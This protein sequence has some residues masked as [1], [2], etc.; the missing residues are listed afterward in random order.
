METKIFYGGT[1]NTTTA[2]RTSPAKG[3]LGSVQVMV[4]RLP[5]GRWEATYYGNPYLHNEINGSSIACTNPTVLV[6]S[7]FRT[8]KEAAETALDILHSELQ[9]WQQAQAKAREEISE[10]RG[11]ARLKKARKIFAARHPEF[12]PNYIKNCSPSDFI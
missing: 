8:R 11:L 2:S 12:N 1:R 9:N 3:V 6:G 5:T 4:R 10:D 7:N